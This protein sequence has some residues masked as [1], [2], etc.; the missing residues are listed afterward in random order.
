MSF[1]VTGNRVVIRKEEVQMKM[2]SILL[3]APT[4]KQNRGV[5][6][7]VGPGKVNDRGIREPMDVK[8]GDKVLYNVHGGQSLHIDNEELFIYYDHDIYAVLED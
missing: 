8:P 6:V 5:V 1:R 7:A 4:Q 3:T 2:G